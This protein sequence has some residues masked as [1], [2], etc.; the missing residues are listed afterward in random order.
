MQ[1][2]SKYYDFVLADVLYY[3]RVSGEMLRIL[4]HGL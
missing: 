1:K 4:K 2:V 3:L